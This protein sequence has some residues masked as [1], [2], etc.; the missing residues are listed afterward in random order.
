MQQYHPD[1]EQLTTPRGVSLWLMESHDLPMV[2]VDVSLRAGSMFE[3]GDKRGLAQLTARLLDEGAGDYASKAFKDEVEGIGARL[4][5][6]ADVQDITLR[7]VMLS[8]HKARAFHLLGMAV[9]SPRFDGEAIGRVRDGMLAD[10]RQGDEDPATVAWRLF[11]PAVFGDH[12]YANS[13]EG[14][15]ESVTGLVRADIQAWHAGNFHKSNMMV[16]VVGDITAEEAIKLVDDAFGALPAGEVKNAVDVGPGLTVPQ[17]VRSHMDVPQGTVLMGHLGF[18][19]HD[20]D[21]YPMLVMNEILGG[22][23]LTSRLGL[24]VR[25]KHGLVYDVRSVNSPLPHNGMF[26]VSFATD[27]TKVEF[28]LELVRKHLN[29]IRDEAVSVEEFEDA[30]A[31]LI[32]S[33]PLRMDSNGKLLNMLSLMQ[34]EDLGVD[35]L[36]EW[37]RRIAAV[38]LEDVR[39][40]AR[41][42]IQP[43]GMVLAVVGRDAGMEG[44]GDRQGT[45]GEMA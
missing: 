24:D 42:L 35:Y 10:I 32:G 12:P 15:L 9:G 11:R 20:E 18:S 44:G 27:N 4:N 14:T 37:P 36:Q 19:R 38:T 21:Y 31:Y 6:D 28:A 39:R 2:N 26:Y 23:V 33:F 1:V 8:E 22:S 40:V 25:E 5:V 34:G 30:K 45:G 17:V 13:G 41:R 3:P 7:M 29:R 43:G 16:S